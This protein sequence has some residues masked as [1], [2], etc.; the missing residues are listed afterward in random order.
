MWRF[1]YKN[2]GEGE[3]GLPCV[4]EEWFGDHTPVSTE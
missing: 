2:I 4:K 1:P 3:M